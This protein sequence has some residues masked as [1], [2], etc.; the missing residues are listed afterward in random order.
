MTRHVH[1]AFASAPGELGGTL[2][3]EAADRRHLERVLRLREGAR[4]E[5]VD[6]A[7]LVFA[8]E[9]EAGGLVRLHELIARRSEQPAPSVWLGSGGGRADLAVEKLTELGVREIGALLCEGTS[10][11][12]RLDRWAR[13]ASAA[14]RQSKR[15]DVPALAGPTPFAEVVGRP[16]V[17]VLDHE[18][19]DA[20]PFAAPA[21]AILLIGPESGLSDAERDLARSYGAPL[22]RLGDGVVLRSE[23][24]AIVS[25][26]VALYGH[27]ANN[28][29]G[30][31]G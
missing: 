11:P 23:T 27:V 20:V 25:A 13:V 3:L 8:G 10:G 12:F 19:P 4:L 9:L 24:A 26:A 15:T 21:D 18:A 16:G 14:G 1:R 7:G 28:R 2:A 5:I 17:I 30:A 22:A 6:A 29:E 31:G